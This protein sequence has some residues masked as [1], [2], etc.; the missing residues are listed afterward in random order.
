MKKKAFAAIALTSCIAFGSTFAG[1][2]LISTNNKRDM[3]QVIATVD[4]SKSD[5]FS[6]DDAKYVEALSSTNIIKRDLVSYFLNVGYSYVQNGYSYE[7]TF[8][9]LVDALV[10]NAILVQ[11]STVELLKKADAEDDSILA[12]FKN[13]K[14]DVEKY[15]I[16]L[17]AIDEDAKNIATYNLYSTINSAID[18]Y[19]KSVIAEEEDSYVGSGSRTT[20]TNLNTEQ[21]DYY[22]KNA[23]G[24]LNYGIY[25]GYGE[26]TLG[27]SGIYNDDALDGTTRATRVKAYNSFINNLRRNN[28][29]DG[30]D[31]TENLRDIWSLK[32]IQTEYASQLESQIINKYYDVYEEEQEENLL[33]DNYV[34]SVYER[35]L[36]AQTENYEDSKAS[37]ESAMSSMSSSSFILYSPETNDSDWYDEDESDP[38]KFAKFGFIYNILLPF[39]SRQSIQLNTLKSIQS[40]DE[41]DDYYYY[42]RNL[43]LQDIETV[44]QR[45]AWFNGS[46]DYSFNV[47]DQDGFKYY[48]GGKDYRKYLFFED[49]LTNN[50]RYKELQAYYGRYS[51]NGAVIENEDESYT[52]IPD[53]L[54]IDGMLAEFESYINYVLNNNGESNTDYVNFNGGYTPG[55]RNDAYYAKPADGFSKKNDKGED[56]IDYSLFTYATGKVNLGDYNSADLMNPNSDY[57]K[58]MSAVNE[59]QF[60]YTTDTSVLSNYIGYSVSA[61]DTNYI[62]EFEYAAKKAVGEG[63]GSFAVCAGDYGWHLIYVTHV[64]EVGTDNYD[65]AKLD[66]S[67]IEEEGTFENLFY[68]WVKSD[69]LTDIST[70]RKTEI[71][72]DYNSDSTVTKYQKRYQDLLD[73]G[74]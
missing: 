13:A 45:S 18:N 37:F 16:L 31:V 62:K 47:D 69:N 41:D 66:W 70:K 68:E 49:N 2:S 26:Y 9:A 8:N 12:A 1:C 57:Y 74:K 72:N 51:Y 32:Y 11:Y 73:L 61:Y 17:D 42:Q 4:I 20:P 43:L 55:T 52:L 29:V 35:V 46:T 38:Y 5:N 48:N 65:P 71:L 30:D 36:A 64:F 33:T 27:N 54:N 60:A 39:S 59:L 63:V 44:D 14:T 34:K 22:P 23:D 56:E 7:Y 6:S 40:A 58:A 15:E 50:D 21:D 67:R 28:L 3:E 24:S 25:T 19:E 10:N 53:K